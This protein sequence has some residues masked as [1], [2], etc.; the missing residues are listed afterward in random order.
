MPLP[1]DSIVYSR[2]VIPKIQRWDCIVNIITRMCEKYFKKNLREHAEVSMIAK[3]T[4]G[5]F[6]CYLMRVFFR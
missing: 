4:V 2:T 6:L 3:N 1:L 5:L